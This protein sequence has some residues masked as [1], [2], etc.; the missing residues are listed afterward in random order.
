LLTV[1]QETKTEVR[2]SRIR[3]V[4]IK[5]CIRNKLTEGSLVH[6]V[7][8]SRK[9]Q[10]PL[11]RPAGSLIGA[12]F[13]SSWNGSGDWFQFG[14][15]YGRVVGVLGA[16]FGCAGGRGCRGPKPATPPP[17][18]G[19]SAGAPNPSRCRKQGA[20]HATG[21]KGAGSGVG[22]GLALPPALGGQ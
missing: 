15:G 21:C 20:V 1:L 18:K 16:Q 13:W 2:D 3:F 5:N 4:F 22:G 6:H 19:N 9:G 12:P 7:G 17:T 11:A 10:A 8:S 14:H